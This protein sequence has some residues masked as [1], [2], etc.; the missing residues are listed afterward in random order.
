MWNYNYYIFNLGI[1]PDFQK[2]GLSKELLISLLRKYR[3]KKIFIQTQLNNSLSNS[4]LPKLGFEFLGS[5]NI[6]DISKIY[7]YFET[8]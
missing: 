5:H 4:V 7:E 2:L 1:L 8:K 3:N 6:I